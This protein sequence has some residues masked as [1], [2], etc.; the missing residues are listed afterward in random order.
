MSEILNPYQSPVA[1]TQP[2]DPEEQ[3]EIDELQRYVNRLLNRGVIFS[4]FWVFGIGSFY[5]VY[6]AAKAHRLIRESAGKISGHKRVWWC[7]LWGGLGVF[8][9]TV[10]LLVVIYNSLQV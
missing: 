9:F 6:L 1:V 10:G 3:E 8:L 4:V 7:Y 2:I 5:S